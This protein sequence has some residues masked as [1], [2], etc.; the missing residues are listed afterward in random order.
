[1]K[2]I[3]SIG[4]FAIHA[5]LSRYDHPRVLLRERGIPVKQAAAE[6]VVLPRP[7]SFAKV[8]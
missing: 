2:I 5:R 4:T 3:F 8:A 7:S 6:R 1:M